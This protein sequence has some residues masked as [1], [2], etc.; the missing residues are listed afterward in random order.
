MLNTV[1]EKYRTL[2]SKIIVGLIEKK[3]KRDT[4]ERDNFGKKVIG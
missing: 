2:G 4:R 3:K 1:F